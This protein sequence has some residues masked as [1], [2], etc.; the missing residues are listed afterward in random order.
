MMRGRG[1]LTPVG[2]NPNSRFA[3]SWGLYYVYTAV[4]RVYGQN[5]NCVGGIAMVTD[6]MGMEV[7]KL[8]DVFMISINPRHNLGGIE[9]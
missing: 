9:T 4:Q 7:N 8:S 6:S 5:L 1:A 2:R 3:E